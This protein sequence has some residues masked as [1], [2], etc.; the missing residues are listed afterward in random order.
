MGR[1]KTYRKI[2]D[3]H[4]GR[5]LPL[6]R[7]LAAQGLGRPLLPGEVVHHRDG[8]SLNNAPDNLLVLPSQRLHAHLEH[9][10]RR[11]RRG[12]SPLFPE[13]LSALREGERAGT[14]FAQIVTEEGNGR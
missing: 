7:Y 14:L 8:N 4:T 3:A 1:G 9:L 12:Q 11:E 5:T 6:H 10:L 2:R 13:L